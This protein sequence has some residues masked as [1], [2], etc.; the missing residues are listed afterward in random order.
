MDGKP[1]G[2]NFARILFGAES[3]LRWGGF[4]DPDIPGPIRDFVLDAIP[5]TLDR[6][7]VYAWK[8][9]RVLVGLWIVLALG[10]LLVSGLLSIDKKAWDDYPMVE[11]WARWFVL[12]IA[13]VGELPPT[14]PSALVPPPEKPPA[15]IDNERLLRL[16]S[17]ANAITAKLNACAV[18]C[19]AG[20]G[21]GAVNLT[22][23]IDQLQ[24]MRATL[25]TDLT[26]LAK[27]PEPPPSQLAH[28][29]PALTAAVTDLTAAVQKP[30]ASEDHRVIEAKLDNLHDQL[31]AFH[32]H[33]TEPQPASH[34][35]VVSGSVDIT[36]H[37]QSEPA[38]TRCKTWT[39]R[40]DGADPSLRPAIARAQSIL[41]P[42]D[43]LKQ[44]FQTDIV[45]EAGKSD[46]SGEGLDRIARVQKQVQ[47][48][49]PLS[50][51]GVTLLAFADPASGEATALPQ[52]RAVE[53]WKL[54]TTGPKR[55][56][57]PL[58]YDHV[59]MLKRRD[60]KPTGS[61]PE[62]RSVVLTVVQPCR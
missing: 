44:L 14:P 22:P 25:H 7:I 5:A 41:R 23:L 11:S 62:N 26:A 37:Q 32:D 36:I 19:T 52:Q 61:Q 10:A 46:V 1:T 21:P 27:A 6:I 43:K 35:D 47:D 17:D 31:A 57:Q 9:I 59:A 39:V 40:S 30:P 50:G 45:F 8:V 16:L 29:I 38:E 2:S 15:A 55:P 54:L 24:D 58:L 56:D 34:Q 51:T 49:D 13:R 53:V 28:A 60:A 18:A 42:N 48:A 4:G 33:R 3:Y 12:S 20:P